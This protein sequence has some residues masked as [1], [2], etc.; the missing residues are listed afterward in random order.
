[1]TVSV[2]TSP[3]HYAVHDPLIIIQASSVDRITA[4]FVDSFQSLSVDRMTAASVDSFQSLSV[5]SIFMCVELQRIEY[6]QLSNLFYTSVDSQHDLTYS[7][8]CSFQISRVCYSYPLS[9]VDEFP[10]Y[11]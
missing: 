8:N 6:L 9:S 4:A 2:V 3:F 5:D 11:N 7:I 10:L 1:M